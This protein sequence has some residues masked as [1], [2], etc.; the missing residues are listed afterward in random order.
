MAEYAARRPTGSE[1]NTTT[2]SP[3]S[4]R[5]KSRPA[6]AVAKM[7]CC[8]ACCLYHLC[9]DGDEVIAANGTRMYS[10]KRASG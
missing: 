7:S 8:L 3:G 4:K 5:E 10:A 2:D 6:L 1:P 9:E